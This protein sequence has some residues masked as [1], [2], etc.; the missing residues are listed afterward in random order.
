MLITLVSS[1]PNC[2]A[3]AC[4]ALVRSMETGAGVTLSLQPRRT[5]QILGPTTQVLAGV[6]RIQEQFCGLD[7]FWGPP[8]FRST[9][10][11][12]NRSCA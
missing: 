6:D 12:R 9:H 7:L 3:V 11:R 1:A 5:N 4:E 8:L 2:V 10:P